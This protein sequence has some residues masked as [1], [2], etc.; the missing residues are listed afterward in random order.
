VPAD[1]DFIYNPET[2]ELIC[3]SS[4]NEIVDWQWT[5]MRT[6]L[7]ENKWIITPVYVS[8]VIIHTY[9]LTVSFSDGNTKSKT[10]KLFDCSYPYQ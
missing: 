6:I 10:Q 7:L 4:S 9:T 3:K 5:Y 1:I 8:I 2:N